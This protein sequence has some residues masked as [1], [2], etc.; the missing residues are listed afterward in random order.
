MEVISSSEDGWWKFFSSSALSEQRIEYDKQLL[1]EFYKNKGFFDAQIESAFVNL[2]KN[3]NFSLTFSVNS[4][5]KYKFG[6][7]D[8]KKVGA[9]YEDKDINEI[10]I[11]SSK[12]LKNQIYSTEIIKKLNKQVTNFL[13]S[14]KYNNFEI[15]IQEFKKEDTINVVFQI[16]DGQKVLINKIN[17]NGNTIT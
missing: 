8:I 5:K 10:K 15:D 11:I 4:G 9:L 1:K 7:F 14:K 12:L 6:D 3:N 16:S 13:E 2:D 17:I